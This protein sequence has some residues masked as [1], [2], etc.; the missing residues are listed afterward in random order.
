MPQKLRKLLQVIKWYSARYNKC[1]GI[2]W[3]PD[4]TM[5]SITSVEALDKSQKNSMWYYWPKHKST[6]RKW[7]KHRGF[8][9]KQN[10]YFQV[11]GNFMLGKFR[12][13]L[14]LYLKVY[15]ILIDQKYKIC[16]ENK[17]CFLKANRMVQCFVICLEIAHL[18]LC[19]K[20]NHM[21]L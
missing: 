4:D 3:V 9:L 14:N 7:R 1:R 16:S 6:L 19:Y 12:Q 8:N 2:R 15:D 10:F 5:P 11:V 17:S 13:I 20:G 18:Y 21:A